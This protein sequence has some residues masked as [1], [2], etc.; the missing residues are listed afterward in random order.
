MD[1][2]KLPVSG[3]APGVVS[4]PA[5]YNDR[6]ANYV[7][8]LHCTGGRQVHINAKC[9]K[10]GINSAPTIPYDVISIGDATIYWDRAQSVKLHAALGRMIAGEDS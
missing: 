1:F 2:P 8:S 7:L 4:L 10:L 3:R 5:V 9:E 6:R